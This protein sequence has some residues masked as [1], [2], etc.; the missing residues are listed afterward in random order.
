MNPSS[1][2]DVLTA[3]YSFELTDEN[4]RRS[5]WYNEDAVGDVEGSISNLAPKNLGMVTAEDILGEASSFQFAASKSASPDPYPSIPQSN[6]LAS[7]SPMSFPMLENKSTNPPGLFSAYT[8]FRTTSLQLEEEYEDS[9]F[10]IYKTQSVA[11]LSMNSDA[12]VGLESISPRNSLKT[13]T[14]NWDVGTP[15]NLPLASPQNLALP[16]IAS[17]LSD[18]S[19]DMSDDNV[20]HVSLES[21]PSILGLRFQPK[22]KTKFEHTEDWMSQQARKAE[23]SRPGLNPNS[24]SV[25]LFTDGEAHCES[26]LHSEWTASS[27]KLPMV[28]HA[29]IG[30]NLSTD[31]HYQD[32][33][34]IDI[35]MPSAE[36]LDSN[37]HLDGRERSHS[38]TSFLD[39]NVSKSPGMHPLQPPQTNQRHSIDSLHNTLTPRDAIVF[40]GEQRWSDIQF[41]NNTLDFTSSILDNYVDE[42]PSV[43]LNMDDHLTEFQRH[44]LHILVTLFS[45]HHEPIC[46]TI[47]MFLDDDGTFVRTYKS[48]S[49]EESSSDMLDEDEDLVVI[50]EAVAE[51][52]SKSFVRAESPVDQWNRDQLH[53][54][55]KGDII[56]KSEVS[57]KSFEIEAVQEDFDS[58]E[59]KQIIEEFVLAEGSYCDCLGALNTYREEMRE[60][61]T[62]EEHRVLFPAQ[63]LLLEN[64][65]RKLLTESK[66][67]LEDPHWLLSDQTTVGLMFLEYQAYFSMYTHYISNQQR[68]LKYYKESILKRLIIA[69]HFQKIHNDNL[70][71]PQLL[72]TPAKRLQAY[73]TF[74]SKLRDCTKQEHSDFQCIL[75]AIHQTDEIIKEAETEKEVTMRGTTSRMDDLF[76]DSTHILSSNRCFIRQDTIEKWCTTTQMWKNFDLFLFN[77]LVLYARWHFHGYKIRHKIPI[78]NLFKCTYKERVLLIEHQIVRKRPFKFRGKSLEWTKE[79]FNDLD[80]LCIQPFRRREYVRRISTGTRQVS[81]GSRRLATVE[82]QITKEITQGSDE[83]KLYDKLFSN[84]DLLSI[85]EHRAQIQERFPD[86]RSLSL[87]NVEDL[88][89]ITPSATQ[90]QLLIDACGSLF[91]EESSASQ[92]SLM[93]TLNV[94]DSQN[95]DREPSTGGSFLSSRSWTAELLENRLL[96]EHVLTEI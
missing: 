12:D 73:R 5:S 83:S 52:I 43:I 76:M 92:P 78:D 37:T 14:H 60:V 27:D 59:R 85:R 87:A 23:A 50:G 58:N 61:L 20:S 4:D 84:Q 25:T 15:S 68:A 94:T 62:E 63:L 17:H 45:V 55:G 95:F 1:G 2:G 66:S 3:R 9:E 71:Y 35:S 11:D 53:S 24:L 80:K 10:E 22:P 13:F 7:A 28:D 69:G 32:T 91:S 18:D 31:P 39:I 72:M 77:D 48:Q 16:E 40:S 56:F 38:N 41:S 19:E 42:S 46:R 47:A 75:Q 65:H 34:Y 81:A 51:A 64:F 30:C 74:L 89:D 88:I 21:L 79:W 26:I 33:G 67:F 93:Q 82:E 86:P 36:F 29:S 57:K 96:E 6:S 90:I 70:D 49:D 8:N 44:I 54:L